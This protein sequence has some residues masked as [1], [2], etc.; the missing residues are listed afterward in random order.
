MTTSALRHEHRRTVTAWQDGRVL[1]QPPGELSTGGR[2]G[3]G[4]LSGSGV[5]GSWRAGIADV[6]V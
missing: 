5:A 2:E 1:F 6:L 3:I 4:S